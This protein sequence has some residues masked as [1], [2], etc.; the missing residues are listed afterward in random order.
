MNKQ[1]AYDV[2]VVGGGLAGTQA[3]AKLNESGCS[4]L[5]LEARDRLGGRTVSVSVD[6]HVVDLGGHWIGGDQRLVYG[7][8]QKFGLKTFPQYDEGTHVLEI[9]GSKTYYKNNISTLNNTDLKGLFKA[10]ETIDKYA[11]TLDPAQPWNAANALEWDSQTVAEWA[12]S[13]VPEPDARAILEWFIRVCMCS[14]PYEVS[15]L[16]FLKFIRSAGS[17]AILADIRGGAQQD[18]PI[19]GAQCI[20]E[21]LA[22]TLGAGRVKLGEPVRAISQDNA[23]VTVTTDRGQ[24][25]ARHV[26]VAVPP[27]LAGK[28]IYSPPMPPMR[29]E[30]T[31]KVPMGTVIKTTVIYDKPFWREAGFSAEAISDKGP[32]FICYDESSHDGKSSA[33]VGFIAGKAARYWGQRPRAERK[34]AVLECYARWWGPKALTCVDFLEMNWSTQQWSCGSYYGVMGPGTLTSCG[35]ALRAPVGNIHWAST[36]TATRWAG[37]MEGALDAGLHVAQEVLNQLQPANRPA[38][39]SRL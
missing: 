14:E 30:L 24:Y 32:I 13:N 35:P 19:D 25:T 2:I 18:R 39:V 29:E 3:A 26:I 15:F 9:N 1:P 37:Y 33:I 8:M 6:G 4:V 5:L 31:Q 28:I 36:E 17:Y 21:K 20:S 34:Q 11:A 12:R 7:L 10:I 27:V 38:L 23:G 22:E 16:F